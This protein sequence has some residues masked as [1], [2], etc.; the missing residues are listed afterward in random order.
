MSFDDDPAGMYAIFKHTRRVEDG[1][2]SLHAR[3]DTHGHGTVVAASSLWRGDIGS[4]RRYRLA[5]GD[6]HT[7]CSAHRLGRAHDRG[8]PA[9]GKWRR[10]A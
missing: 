7:H 5:F 6:R 3:R 9:A 2:P 4:P 10:A 1:A 8:E